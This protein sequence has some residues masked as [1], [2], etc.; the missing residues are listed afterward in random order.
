MGRKKD[1]IRKKET[2]LTFLA[3]SRYVWLIDIRKTQNLYKILYKI[4]SKLIQ[5]VKPIGSQNATHVISYVF[6][7]TKFLLKPIFRI[8]Y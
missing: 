4:Y 5:N 3:P 7:Y 6:F 1:L 2:E 8:R